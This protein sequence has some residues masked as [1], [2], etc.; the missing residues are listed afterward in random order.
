MNNLKSYITAFRIKTIDQFERVAS[1]I[2]DGDITFS[3]VIT[4][5][6]HRDCVRLK[7]T[8]TKPA[9]DTRIF[10]NPKTFKVCYTIMKKNKSNLKYA[11]INTKSNLFKEIKQMLNIRSI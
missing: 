3:S 1:Q 7:I 6:M 5:G 4:E 11:I 2:T 9:L 8:Y 10:I